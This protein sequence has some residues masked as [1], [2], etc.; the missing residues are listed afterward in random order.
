MA[1][2]KKYNV[3][4]N[5]RNMSIV[6]DFITHSETYFKCLSTSDCWQDVLGHF[7]LFKPDVYLCFV[8]S[9]Y[10]KILSQTNALRGDALYND[11]PIFVVADEETYDELEQNPR[12]AISVVIKRPIS[13][14]NLIL[15][16][17]AHLEQR[18]RA[19]QAEAEKEAKRLAE[20]ERRK[21][22][23]NQ[24]TPFNKQQE[25]QTPKRSAIWETWENEIKP[26]DTKP[27]KKIKPAKPAQALKTDSEK[28]AAEAAKPDET[29]AQPADS[30]SGKKHILIVDDDRTVLKMLK[31][32]LEEEYDVTTMVNGLMVE[33]FLMAKKVDVV[34][35]DYE[36]PGQT[37]A[38]IFRKLKAN[39]KTE[40]IPV[41]FLTGISDREKILE[42]MSLKPHSYLLKPI[43]M[44]ML[45]A[46]IT[47]LTH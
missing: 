23:A 30:G 37:G 34:I 16:I 41:C 20:L 47:N 25:D 40:K 8:D 36:M 43:D 5:G 26:I 10:S 31:S 32:A 6:M 21:A 18:E 9:I 11:A 42:V 29:K 3:L 7:E 28:I 14:D 13:T 12:P 44:D 1:P 22:A 24:K 27:I 15:R 35:L 46:A 33:K 2:S 19:A 39:E 4:I 45:K 17:T 38:D